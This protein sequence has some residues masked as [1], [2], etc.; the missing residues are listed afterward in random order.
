MEYNEII[1]AR[2]S[3]HDARIAALEQMIA[4][5]AR[6]GTVTPKRRK[7]ELTPE[8]RVAVRARLLAGQEAARKRRE[9]EARAQAKAVKNGNKEAT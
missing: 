1:D 3:A 5:L 9:A 7:R 4:T 8:E 2:L 6:G